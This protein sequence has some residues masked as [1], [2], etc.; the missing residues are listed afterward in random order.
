MTARRFDV[1]AGDT[2][3]PITALRPRRRGQR[4]DGRRRCRRALVRPA[5]PCAGADARR[6]GDGRRRPRRA[7]R[8]LAPARSPRRGRAVLHAAP[9]RRARGDLAYLL[10]SVAGHRVP[11]PQ[12]QPRRRHGRGWRDPR[13]AALHGR[14]APVPEVRAGHDV[15]VRR[16]AYP[17]RPARA[18][19]AGHV[20]PRLLR[21]ARP[22]GLLRG[23]RGGGAHPP[24]GRLPRGVLLSAC[25]VSL[26][27]HLPEVDVAIV[28]GGPAGALT[29]IALARTAPLLQVAVVEPAA[30]LGTGRAFATAD[31]RHLLNVAAGAMSALPDE[32]DHL[33]AWAHTA[34]EGGATPR[35]FLPRGL[36]GRYLADTVSATAP[37]LVHVRGAVS[38]LGRRGQ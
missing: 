33:V 8:A 29:A 3:H 18:R 31:E 34:G 6:A 5:R 23:D 11:R 19:P 35:T 12:R 22:D 10:V 16:R 26:S 2:P 13:D 25:G 28:G 36:Y 32:P 15:R 30:H 14:L 9:P 4:A 7:P 17:R 27:R 1:G 24:D 37:E 20:A 21:A 38:S